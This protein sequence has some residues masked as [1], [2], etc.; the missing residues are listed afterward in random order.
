MTFDT[1][2]NLAP[3]Q[4]SALAQHIEAARTYAAAAKADATRRAYAGDVERWRAWAE[5][6]GAQVLPAQPEA[7]AVYL[8]HLA[9]EGRKVAT[10]ERALAGI[11]SASRAA[12]SWARG[13][14]AIGAVMAG[15]KRT[16][17]IAPQRKAALEVP[18]LRALVASLDVA[19][20]SGLRDRAVLL[21]GWFGAFRRSELAH[22]EV[23][24]VQF[25][26]EGIEVRLKRSKTDK[27]GA[28]AVRG[29]PYAGDAACCPVRA[30]RAYLEAT[31]I[32]NGA[33]FRSINR[34]GQVGDSL[35][36]KGIAR[37]V[38]GAAERAGLDATT[39]GGHSL[40]AGFATA[41]ARQG[42]SLDAIMRQTGHRS[43]RVARGYIRHATLFTN[44][45][46]AGLL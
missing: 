44:N 35:S 33:L 41:A 4:P 14:A 25:V 17:G 27:N 31:G 16:H 29:L 40:R 36:D 2:A 38:Q 20:L 11:A 42:R 9:S 22:L 6:H 3:S 45:A 18:Q 13:H 32:E 39:F 43:E 15:I 46:A 10:I 8:A 24:D 21:V 12:G 5:A 37:I 19:T 1:A 28:G 23:G 30:L 7:V 34:H 26:N